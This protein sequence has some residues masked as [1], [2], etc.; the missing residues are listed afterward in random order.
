MLSVRFDIRMEINSGGENE[1]I[2]ENN[3]LGLN[4]MFGRHDND[5]LILL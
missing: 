1:S 3:Y 4:L 5:G 2:T